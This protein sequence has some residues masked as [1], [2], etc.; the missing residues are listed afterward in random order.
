MREVREF[1]KFRRQ[2]L[3]TST[4]HIMA[5]GFEERCLAYPKVL[6]GNLGSK[7]QAFLAIKV[8][9]DNVSQTLVALSEQN[10]SEMRKLLPSVQIQPLSYLLDTLRTMAVPSNYCV[11]TSAM[12]RFCI[13][14]VL[15][16][17]LRKSRGDASVFVA[18][19][20]PTRFVHGNLQEPA[21]DVAIYYDTPS[22]ISGK[23]VTAFVMPGFDIDYTNVALV[24][25]K[26]ATALPPS[27]RWLF[28]FPGRKYQFYER[29]LETH[30]EMMAGERLEFFPQDEINI[31]AEKLYTKITSIRH[32]SVFCVPLGCRLTCVP[33]F[34]AVW[35]ARIVQKADDTVNIL[36]PKTRR[37]SSLRSEGGDTPLIEELRGIGD[38]EPL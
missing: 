23:K 3:A 2:I 38:I 17:I 34:L 37:Y 20:Y 16:T 26:A 33:L 15:S 35:R 36:V 9:E 8:S 18:Y 10:E 13:H 24:H 29:A 11:D 4:I 31:A 27:I 25:I 12:P 7:G 6:R 1:P 32:G 22:L 21:T 19:S 5:V 28:S 14:E 30:G